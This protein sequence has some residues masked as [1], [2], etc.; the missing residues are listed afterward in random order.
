MAEQQTYRQNGTEY[1]YVRSSAKEHCCPN[2]S[3]TET[4][5]VE[6]GKRREISGVHVGF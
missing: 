1:Y 4:S 3:S 5:I 6:T 2:C